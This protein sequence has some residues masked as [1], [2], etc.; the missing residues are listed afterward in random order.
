MLEDILLIFNQIKDIMFQSINIDIIVLIVTIIL[1]SCLLLYVVWFA[2][3]KLVIGLKGA[4]HGNLLSE[5][6]FR[7]A[8]KKGNYDDSINY[9]EHEVEY[10]E[11][12]ITMSDIG[13]FFDN[14]LM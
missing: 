6:K 5:Y 1:S 11:D 13:S 7:R 8:Y 10:Y 4:L 9:D 14:D 3:R 2:I 12:N